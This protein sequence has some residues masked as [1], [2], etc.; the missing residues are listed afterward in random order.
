MLYYGTVIEIEGN[1]LHVKLPSVGG[2][3]R[4]GPLPSVILQVIDTENVVLETSYNVGDK[5]VVGQVAH[6]KDEFVVLG[7]I[8]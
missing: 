4:I 8:G 7:R 3:H 5:V 1:H 2:D 6:M